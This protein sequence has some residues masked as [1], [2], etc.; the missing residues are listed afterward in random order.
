MIKKVMQRV[1]SAGAAVLLLGIFAPLL[2]IVVGATYVMAIGFVMLMISLA[3]SIRYELVENEGIDNR[4]TVAVLNGLSVLFAD[5]SETFMMAAIGHLLAIG[6]GTSA[7][8][9]VITLPAS[10]LFGWLAVKLLAI[11]KTLQSEEED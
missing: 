4:Y 2:N 5:L 10:I 6:S 11:V 9:V 7:L 8:V 3:A 1:G